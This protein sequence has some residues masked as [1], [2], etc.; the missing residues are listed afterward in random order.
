[1]LSGVTYICVHLPDLKFSPVRARS[2]LGV[3][4][5]GLSADMIW[6]CASLHRIRLWIIVDLFSFRN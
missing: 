4:E 6:Y 5:R 2:E 1:M 3:K